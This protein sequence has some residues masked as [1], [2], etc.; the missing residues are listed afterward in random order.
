MQLGQDLRKYSSL[1]TNGVA[2]ASIRHVPDEKQSDKLSELQ[3]GIRELFR[4][5]V[6]GAYVLGLLMLLTPGNALVRLAEQG[7][8]SQLVASLFFGMVG[9]ALRLHERCFPYFVLFEKYRKPLNDAII[10]TTSKGGGRDN[11]DVYKYFL[12]TSDSPLRNRVHYF[13]S[14]YYMLVELSY[15]SV[16]AGFYLLASDLLAKI[17][18]SYEISRHL[19]VASILIGVAGQVLLLGGLTGIEGRKYKVMAI[20]SV[21][22]PFAGLAILIFI[23]GLPSSWECFSKGGGVP[24]L[25]ILAFAFERLGAKH[26]KQII[27]EQVIFVKHESEYLNEITKKQGSAL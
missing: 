8:S 16:V 12:E 20:L 6:P 25:L 1:L 4:I 2:V 15:I 11:V 10:E 19:A 5:L 17:G 27:S 9:Y 23:A 21:C 22:L 24:A 3:L 14:F 26:W 13:S 7:A 18:V